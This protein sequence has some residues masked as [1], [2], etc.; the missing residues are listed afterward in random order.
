[1][2]LISGP[3][4]GAHFRTHGS[5]HFRTPQWGS[6]QD[7]L[8]GRGSDPSSEG[9]LQYSI[10]T[11]HITLRCELLIGSDRP[12]DFEMRGLGAPSW[13][14]TL[15]G[16]LTGGDPSFAPYS[17]SLIGSEQMRGPGGLRSW[18]GTG[19]LMGADPWSP[20][21]LSSLSL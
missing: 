5:A 17:E 8:L 10:N 3:V 7:P 16:A 1:M 12:H 19:A 4:N 14:R 13:E 18:E 20:H 9:T 11:D 15:G 2:G 21:L 6:F